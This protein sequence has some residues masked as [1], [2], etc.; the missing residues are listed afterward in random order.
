MRDH[1]IEA[2]ILVIYLKPKVMDFNSK[3]NKFY[4]VSTC[5]HLQKIHMT[6][7]EKHTIKMDN[8]LN[9][10]VA[11]ILVQLEQANKDSTHI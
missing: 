2:S 6:L 4:V 1:A 7:S 9:R 5:S 8:A 11:A 3:G 10:A